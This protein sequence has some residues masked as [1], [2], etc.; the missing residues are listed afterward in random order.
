[1]YSINSTRPVSTVGLRGIKLKSRSSAPFCK[2]KA[3][4][5]TT[6]LRRSRRRFILQGRSRL[7]AFGFRLQP[8][9]DSTSANKR[10][11][12]AAVRSKEDQPVRGAWHEPR[13]GWALYYIALRR[14]IEG[15]PEHPTLASTVG[16]DAESVDDVQDVL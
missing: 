14:R 5:R 2:G 6:A 8:Y 3:I 7:W 10:R 1:M 9:W 16:A 12:R 13:I 15:K 4:L 11:R